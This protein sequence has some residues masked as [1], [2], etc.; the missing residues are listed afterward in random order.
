MNRPDKDTLGMTDLGRKVLDDLRDGEFIND[1]VDG[2]RFAFALAI[3]RRLEP[4]S[5]DIRTTTTWN[6]GTFDGD[7]LL[8]DLVV[9]LRPESADAPY[10]YIERL[11]DSG[12]QELRRLQETG[13]MRF[14]DLFAPTD[15]TEI[16]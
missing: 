2:Y 4:S 10:R 8:R 16:P 13:Q 9:I 12:L 1:L 5:S 14:S 15:L 6:V 3:E 7:Q 11:A